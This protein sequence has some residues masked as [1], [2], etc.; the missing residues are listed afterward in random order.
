[1]PAWNRALAINPRFGM[2]LGNRGYGLYRY[3]RSLHDRGHACVFVAFAHNDLTAALAPDAIYEGYNREDAKAIFAEQKAEIEKAIDV[4]KIKRSLRLDGD[5]LGRS[6]QERRYRRWTL[7]EVLFLNPLN[8]LGT[9]KIAA[10]DVF[11][12][13]DFTTPLGEP[14]TL[15]GLFNQIKQEFV[16]ARWL[17]FEGLNAQ[18]THFSDR[19]ALLYNT[20]DYPSYALA[21]EKVKAAF[22]VADFLFDKIAFFLN[23]YAKLNVPTTRTR[24][25]GSSARAYSIGQLAV[26]RP[27]LAGEGP[28]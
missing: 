20:L 19:D 8:D 15:V 12:L 21:I 24:K 16:S 4:K 22:R 3:A 23:N 1:L 28:I 27:L 10:R 25:S 13:P 18:T 26:A 6:R 7:D 2:A 9:Y 17:L 14:P 11:S 5:K